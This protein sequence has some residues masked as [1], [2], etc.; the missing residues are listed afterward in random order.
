MKDLLNRLQKAVEAM[1]NP[2]PDAP[3]DT[4]EV[5]LEGC[6]AHLAEQVEKVAK[7]P[8]EVR[9]ARLAHIMAVI[10]V[11]KN[12]EGPTGGAMR[13]PA[14]KDPGQT[15]PTAPA[16]AQVPKNAPVATNATANEAPQPAGKPAT[17]AGGQ[18]PP[19][20]AGSS[21]FDSPAAATFAKSM[22]EL[23]KAI[24]ELAKGQAG[25]PPAGDPPAGDPPA[26]T[27]GDAGE[28]KPVQKSNLNPVWPLDMN[29]PFGRGETEDDGTPDWGFDP[30]SDAA[31]RI[32]AEREG[33]KAAE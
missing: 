10:D 23:Q 19:M 20:T 6:V 2:N 28:Q 11:A 9:P 27:E 4:V 24:A 22:E 33:D 12:F 25:D 16:Q 32:A 15:S 26:K 13:I 31:D 30:K 18:V 8:A 7:D 17:P 5:T 3:E 21:G 14:F 29:T 1:A